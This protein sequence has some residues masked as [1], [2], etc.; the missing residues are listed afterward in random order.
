MLFQD[1]G[2]GWLRS[3]AELALGGTVETKAL[4][5]NWLIAVAF[6]AGVNEKDASVK[7]CK[8]TIFLFLHVHW[9]MADTEKEEETHRHA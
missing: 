8:L 9:R 1:L 3:F 7:T 4:I 5:T 2:G 6:L